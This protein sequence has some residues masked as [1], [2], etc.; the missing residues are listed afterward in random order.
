MARRYDT[1]REPTS[2]SYG[3]LRPSVKRKEILFFSFSKRAKTKEKKC[4]LNLYLQWYLL[5]WSL[6]QWD[7]LHT[8]TMWVSICCL[9]LGLT[10]PQSFPLAVFPQTFQV[11]FIFP[12]SAFIIIEFSWALRSS[13]LVS[14]GARNLLV[15]TGT[16]QKSLWFCC[17][18]LQTVVVCKDNLLV[19]ESVFI[20]WECIF[21]FRT[22]LKKGLLAVSI[23]L[24][25]SICWSPSHKRVTSQK[26]ESFLQSCK[27][28]ITF[29][30]NSFH[31]KENFWDMKVMFRW[32]SHIYSDLPGS[33]G[34]GYQTR[35]VWA[36]STIHGLPNKGE[37]RAILYFLV[38]CGAL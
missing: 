31:F 2:S 22:E 37:A 16:L 4:K 18:F 9:M 24:W 32:V 10:S 35:G 5:T 13:L 27:E 11:Y 14:K 26:S 36:E 21:F 7:V 33:I 19:R 38:W 1:L 20:G 8:L 17:H 6:R 34:R 23:I 28:L 12:S 15:I 25:A 30:W 3:G 29:L